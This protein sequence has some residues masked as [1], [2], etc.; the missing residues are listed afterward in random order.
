MFLKKEFKSF[1]KR[2]IIFF[3]NDK[4]NIKE[5]VAIQSNFC[6]NIQ[7]EFNYYIEDAIFTLKEITI[8]F[9]NSPTNYLLNK[10]QT[11]IKNFDLNKG[12]I[13]R[14]L[15]EI[16]VCFDLDFSKDLYEYFNNNKLD[17]DQY[18]SRFIK[19][20][21]NVYH[22]GFLPGFF[23][24]RGLPKSLYLPRKATPSSSVEPGTLAVGGSYVGIYPQNSPGGW[25]RIGRCYYSFFNKSKNPPC[26][27]KPGDRI[28]FKNIQLEEFNKKIIS[29]A[30]RNKLPKSTP[31]EIIY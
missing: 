27:A 15:W 18:I 16:P 23:Y 10:I 22:Y 28:I 13:E 4:Q 26:F 8:I 6:E 30:A 9:K 25:Q 1:G 5:I 14:S 19:R 21:F 11:W 2:A 20:T 17:C 24:L 3:V 31:F 29:S 7:N 12:I